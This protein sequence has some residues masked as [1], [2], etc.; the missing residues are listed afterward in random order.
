MSALKK[1]MN[2]AK[3]DTDMDRIA[4]WLDKIYPRV[5]ARLEEN[6]K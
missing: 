6:L 5:S 1:E 3:E 4:N 2:S